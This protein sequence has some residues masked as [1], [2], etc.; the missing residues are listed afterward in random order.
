MSHHEWNYT[1]YGIEL[2]SNNPSNEK[3]FA[4]VE[5]HKEVFKWFADENYFP[6]TPYDIDDFLY[7]YEDDCGN[8]GIGVLIA[9]VVG[10]MFV[11]AAYDQYGNEFVGMY[12]TTMFPWHHNRMG[13]EWKSITPEYIED[14][15]RPVVE[16]LYGMCPDFTEHTIWQNG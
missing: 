11:N 6:E 5:N 10:N 12:A 4:F 2:P 16:E 7:D 3:I 8:N 9:D 14:C 1:M 13:G 15:I